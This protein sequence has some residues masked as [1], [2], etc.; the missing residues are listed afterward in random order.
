VKSLNVDID[1]N[2]IDS[3]NGDKRDVKRV[4]FIVAQFLVLIIDLFGGPN[5]DDLVWLL[6]GLTGLVF[7]CISSIKYAPG[8]GWFRYLANLL[9]VLI[10]SIIGWFLILIF[11]FNVF[12]DG[13]GG[14]ILI[15]LSPMLALWSTG[16]FALLHLGPFKP[17]SS[18]FSSL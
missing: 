14:G 8:I 7:I 6:T 10:I 5:I 9:I 3:H 16:W 15:L 13:G 1:D 17:R 4:I 11:I 18:R 2:N 12:Y